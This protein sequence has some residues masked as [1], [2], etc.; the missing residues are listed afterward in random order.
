MNSTAEQ[1]V[2]KE[3][4]GVSHIKQ[5][6]EV[7]GS[8]LSTGSSPNISQP[9]VVRDAPTQPPDPKSL[10]IN[11]SV[12]S[13]PGS[14][15]GVKG[16][17]R[18]GSIASSRRS[19][20]K[21]KATSARGDL[22]TP[23]TAASGLPEKKKG[24]GVPRLLSFLN[25]CSAPEDANPID[26]DNQ[27]SPPRKTNKIPPNQGR[28]ATPVRKPDVSAAESSTAESKEMSDEKIG[29]P[30]YS[31]IKAAEQ[32]KI[33]DKQLEP[34]STSKPPASGSQESREM[35][36]E[37]KPAVRQPSDQLDGTSGAPMSMG[38]PAEAVAPPN[39][40][41]TLPT[42]PEPSTIPT[43]VQ[44]STINDRTPEQEERDKDI[45]MVDAPPADPV[46][47]GSVQV[48]ESN[49][50]LPPPPPLAPQSDP[51]SSSAG[52]NRSSV[53]SANAISE[54]QTWL[55]PPVR[56]EFHGKKCL[57][58]DLDETLVHSSFK[59]WDYPRG[60]MGFAKCSRHYIKPTSQFQ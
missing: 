26:S 57:V 19:K 35:K 33:Q 22:P 37:E 7:A 43:P 13:R 42:P 45:E 30:P 40:P 18:N 6:T 5:E 48:A 53:T 49:Q 47:H 10:P 55:L 58:L 11:P 4:L 34:P 9:K 41:E 21:E 56:P 59:V 20:P 17:E 8:E 51:S 31:E 27:I 50:P 38:M 39:V 28:Q 23:T 44:E 15:S 16:H 24:K 12:P 25:C 46:D 32:P 2:A 14:G 1:P 36:Q 54:R 52:A 60:F 29:G 3:N